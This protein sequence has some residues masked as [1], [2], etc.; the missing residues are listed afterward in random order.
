LFALQIVE[1]ADRTPPQR[2]YGMFEQATKDLET[3]LA[4]WNALKARFV[5]TLA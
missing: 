2:A 1:S 5:S 3:L 4:E